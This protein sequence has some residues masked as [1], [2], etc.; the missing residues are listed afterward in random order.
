MP[1]YV[2]VLAIIFLFVVAMAALGVCAYD[3]ALNLPIPPIVNTALSAA[4]ASALHIVGLSYGV[5]IGEN[6]A[7]VAAA[8]DQ[9]S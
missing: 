8:K 3:I 1:N 6:N 5:S 2:K 9:K 4:V 7:A